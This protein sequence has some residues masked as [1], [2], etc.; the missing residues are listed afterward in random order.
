MRP[1]EI[2]I[3]LRECAGWSKSALGAH[4]QGTVSDVA[5]QMYWSKRYKLDDLVKDTISFDLHKNTLFFYY[6]TSTM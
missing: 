3:S 1:A 5:A 6:E 2:Q 4:V